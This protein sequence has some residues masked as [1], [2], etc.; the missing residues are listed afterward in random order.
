MRR[1]ARFTVQ[2]IGHE[3]MTMTPEHLAVALTAGLTLPPQAAEMAAAYLALPERSVSERA[4]PADA[5]ATVAFWRDAGPSRWF[6]K[7]A[8]FDR[9]FRERFL[10]LHERAACEALPEW[11][12]TPIGSLAL[13]ILLDQFPRNAFRGTARM[14]ATDALAR[15]IADAARTTA[16][17]LLLWS[18]AAT[19]SLRAAA[20]EARRSGRLSCARLDA[21]LP[22]ARLATCAIGLPAGRA[23]G[24]ALQ[25]LFDPPAMAGA[26]QRAPSPRKPA[27]G[28][29][30]RF[31][32]LAVVVLALAAGWTAYSTNTDVAARVNGLL[33][34]AQAM[35][36]S[37]K[38]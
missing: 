13:A 5:E 18:R 15:Q 36:H 1:M 28:N 37:I 17:V 12:E 30:G 27:R 35:A 6:A 2:T 26:K 9:A 10:W 21:S 11:L 20:K 7:D 4:A 38:R 23:Q 22:P 16:N 3:A 34:T 31:A 8:D 32:A 29:L 25:R 33:N 19:P 24:A 14:Y